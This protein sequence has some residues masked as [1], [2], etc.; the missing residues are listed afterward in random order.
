MRATCQCARSTLRS[1]SCT[2]SLRLRSRAGAISPMPRRRIPR[3]TTRRL[4]L[5]SIP[6]TAAPPGGLTFPTW[7]SRGWSATGSSRANSSGRAS[8]TSASRRRTRT[9]AE[10]P[11]SESATS[12]RCRRTATGSTARTGT[13]GRT[14]S[15]SCRTGTGMVAK[16]RRSRSYATRA[17]TRRSFS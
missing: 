5:T 3:T 1:R 11:S 2:L 9:C 12:A 4:S 8:T 13:I 6:T 17:A 15:I 16:A 10:A 7:S 14:R